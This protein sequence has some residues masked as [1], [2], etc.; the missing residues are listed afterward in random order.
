MGTVQSIPSNGNRTMVDFINDKFEINGIYI[1]IN[2]KGE[3]T[4]MTIEY[5]FRVEDN[6]MYRNFG[7]TEKIRTLILHIDGSTLTVN[8]NGLI[9][10]F[11]G[12]GNKLNILQDG[13]QF[14]TYKR[15]I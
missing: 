8:D 3:T 9:L 12:F 2:E 4:E 15:K 11:I 5:L 13:K 10:K 7:E 6:I 14:R 1:L